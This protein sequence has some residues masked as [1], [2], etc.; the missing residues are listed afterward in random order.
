MWHSGMR[1]TGQKQL[2]QKL[3]TLML[4]T[5]KTHSVERA[6]AAAARFFTI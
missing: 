4:L 2:R 1:C 6:A 3:R 5:K